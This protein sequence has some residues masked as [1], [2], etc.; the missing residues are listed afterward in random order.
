MHE[1]SIARNILDTVAAEQ[2][3]HGFTRVTCV[4]LRIGRFSNV[5]PESLRFGFEALRVGTP[6]AEAV[7]VIETTEGRLECGRCGDVFSALGDPTSCP[8][9]ASEML[10]LCSG[11]ELDIVS[12]EVM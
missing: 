12:I 1:L 5:V 8:R 2:E 10:H 7:L 11:E 4:R 9:C 3:R 6:A